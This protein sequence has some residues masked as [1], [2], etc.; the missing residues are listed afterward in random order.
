MELQLAEAVRAA[1]DPY[2]PQATKQQAN[3]FLEQCKQS[4]DGWESC[5]SIYV[6]AQGSS[7]PQL[8]FFCLQVVEAVLADKQRYESM[9]D[10]KKLQLQRSLVSYLQTTYQ[11]SGVEDSSFNKNKLAQVVT[12]VFVRQYPERWPSFFDELLA[13][14]PAHLASAASAASLV[15]AAKTLSAVGGA[16]VATDTKGARMIDIFLR[17]C[18]A[19]DQEVVNLLINREKDAIA[20]N[21]HIKD[22]MRERAVHQLVAVWYLII[23][24]YHASHPDFAVACLQN[25]GLF[26]SWIDVGLVVNEQY[27]PIIFR[28]LSPETS[29]SSTQM[30]RGAA[31]ECLRDILSKGMRPADKL[32]MIRMIGLVDVL[33]Q[34]CSTLSLQSQAAANGGDAGEDLVEHAAKLVNTVGY[35]LVAASMELSDDA[36]AQANAFE[37][38]QRV[39]VHAINIFANEYD[40][41]TSAVFDFC[42]ELLS[43]LKQQKKSAGALTAVQTEM[44]ASLLRVVILKMK[45]DPEADVS[46]DAIEDEDDDDALFQHLR[47]Q[48]KVFFDNI[49]LIDQKLWSEY[50]STAVMATLRQVESGANVQWN[51]VELALHILYLFGESQKVSSTYQTGKAANGAVIVT[52]DGSLTV[53]GELL[54]ELIKSHV[55][56]YQHPLVPPLFFE[57]VVRYADFFEHFPDAIAQALA[58]FC[59]ARGLHHQNIAVRSRATYLFS[60]FIRAT[61]GKIAPYVEMVLNAVSDL[62]SVSPETALATRTS[63]DDADGSAN[64]SPAFDTQTNLFEAVGVLIS[65]DGIALETRSQ[66]TAIVLNPLIASLD[67]V[68]RRQ[69][70]NTNSAD[71]AQMWVTHTRNLIGAVGS[72]SK[73]YPSYQSQS[74][75]PWLPLFRSATETI[76]K[77]LELLKQ[78]EIIRESVRFA[79]QRM[80]HVLGPEGFVYLPPMVVALLSECHERELGDF[81]SF[82]GLIMHKYKGEMLPVMNTLVLPIIQQ[83][84]AFVGRTPSGTDELILQNDLKRAYLSFLGSLFQTELDKALLQKD[85][86][87]HSATVIQ[88]VTHYA[89]DVTDKQQA[90]KSAIGL[91]GKIVSAWSGF[92]SAGQAAAYP[93]LTTGWFDEPARETVA[94]ICFEVPLQDSFQLSD[95]KSLLVMHEIANLQKVVLLKQGTD[96]VQ[97]LAQGYFPRIQCPP[98]LAAEYVAALQQLD[99]KKFQDYVK[100]F[101]TQSKR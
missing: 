59:D 50:S 27:I 51:D 7:N 5:W 80:L 47:K 53:L 6:S 62:L 85:N 56:D 64:G 63:T 72:V 25:V 82:I 66:Y 14:L 52:S 37:L 2:S 26:I 10:D 9:S 15:S 44:V 73:D 99:A 48:L 87:V 32:D 84:F 75:S 98:A 49:A 21:N 61:R 69:P 81:L 11:T 45:Y 68:V 54:V 24:G 65:L 34:L 3:A 77:A 90:Q 60:R 100:N 88:S 43:L 70:W 71:D 74:P 58:P 93:H 78:H 97:F 42:T 41:V 17:I 94:R 92:P 57:L 86:Y 39:F 35:E 95:A 89:T 23:V 79:L 67:D 19:I 8:R 12:L 96:F 4:P 38:I 20:H 46:P 101:I 16:S 13:L 76:L 83:V 1:L 22:M 36:Q 29:T 55:A 40:D 91:F 18:L 28:F 31:A 33:D 30:L